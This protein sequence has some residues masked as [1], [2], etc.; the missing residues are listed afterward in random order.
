MT[1][2]VS[3]PR[4]A[5]RMFI[6]ITKVVE[7]KRLVYGVATAELP[8][9]SGE[10]CDYATS[11]PYFQAWSGEIEKAS[12]GKSLGNV[13]AMHG[14]VAAGKVTEIN[15][16]DAAKRIEVAAKIV[17]DD[18]WKKVMEGVYTGFSQGGRYVRRWRDDGDGNLTRYTAEPSEISIV[19]LP[20]LPDATFSVIKMDAGAEIIEERHFKATASSG[21]IVTEPTAEDIEAKAQDLA[22]AGGGD[23]KVSE[24]HR[25]EARAM[26]M[27]KEPP[28]PPAKTITENA[29]KAAS[30]DEPSQFWDC[31]NPEHRHEKK[32]EAKL[33]KRARRV[34]EV[35]KAATA[36]VDEKFAALSAALGIEEGDAE[37]EYYVRFVK[38]G[39]APGEGDKPYGDVRY[40]DPGYQS[41]KQKRYPIDNE[42][43]IRAAWSYI[44]KPKNA[45][46]YTAE[47]V[48][49]IKA[50]IIAAWKKKIDKEGP[51]AAQEE[52]KAAD[53]DLTK[54]M[55]GVNYMATHSA[56]AKFHSHQA[57]SAGDG[58]DGADG[59][60]ELHKAAAG[61]HAEAFMAHH[62]DMADKMAKSDMAFDATRKCYGMGK[63]APSDV[64]W[65]KARAALSGGSPAIGK[66]L[67]AR[68]TAKFGKGLATVGQLSFLL[69]Q[70]YDLCEA[71]HEE[72]EAE[73]D[74][75]PLCDM[76]E[77]A[78]KSVSAV[79]VAM[80]QE[81]TDELFQEDGSGED[82]DAASEPA[83]AL[84][85]MSAH[86]AEPLVKFLSE[87]G[88]RKRTAAALAKHIPN[89]KVAALARAAEDLR[90]DVEKRGARHSAADQAR[91]Q[92][93]HDLM[94]ELGAECGTTAS[95]AKMGEAADLLKSRMDDLA[96][97]NAA[98]KATLS[99]YGPKLDAV[100]AKLAAIEAL[101]MP[102]RASLRAVA[103]DADRAADGPM[104]KSV[105]DFMASLEKMTP[106][107]RALALTKLSLRMPL[108][109]N[110]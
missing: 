76:F 47:Q 105:E 46:Q 33:C 48:D 59:C 34:A 83:M 8:D 44:N 27:A 107:E 7:E 104:R 79:L 52:N 90:A 55:D 81:E 30:P 85:A 101:P 4:D 53:G 99:G 18:E 17:D 20:C 43:H 77:D 86:Y 60:G 92:K 37:D 29:D 84:A 38:G 88:N 70:L 50:R 74:N 3:A 9:R 28:E 21:D 10:I 94:K 65:E 26:L 49:R 57:A 72:A 71:C 62:A 15:F 75:T 1:A 95:G 73:G 45:S 64:Q 63:A 110:G 106:D 2:H 69:S 109:V 68:V 93:A 89:S 5:L 23:G 102:A 91:L 14:N 61:A 39:D 41:D 98:L 108:P 66:A 56:M 25:R 54:D 35:A 87:A 11:K 31:G 16:D 36:P 67:R 100:M 96:V 78:V 40:A 6:P 58:A 19:D 80:A 13:R 82:Y 12:G 97:E 42:Q 32:A 22:S 24:H 103:K 51:P